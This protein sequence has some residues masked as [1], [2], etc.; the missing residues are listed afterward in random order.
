[1]FKSG[2]ARCVITPDI[3]NCPVPLAGLGR[4]DIRISNAVL[5]DITATA[6]VISDGED[7]AVLI[8][9]ETLYAGDL[10]SAKIRRA[11]SERLS[12][13]E[14]NITV[15]GT[16]THCS[17]AVE[18]VSNPNVRRWIDENAEKIGETAKKAYDALSET[19]LYGAS[20]QTDGINSV[21]RYKYADGEITSSVSTGRV[22]TSGEVAHE[23]EGDRE[24][25]VLRFK[26]RGGRDIIMVNFQTHPTGD[27]DMSQGIYRVSPQTFGRTREVFES[28]YPDVDYVYFNGAAGNVDVKGPMPEKKFEQGE[29]YDN[30]FIKYVN[31]ALLKAEPIKTGK[32]KA[33]TYMAPAEINHTRADL[34]DKAWEL[35][36]I[37]RN[38]KSEN[39]KDAY[40]AFDENGFRSIQ[41]VMS[42]I[43]NEDKLKG[44]RYADLYLSAISAGDVSFVSV[45]YEMFAESGAQV[46][47]ASPFKMTMIFS[48]A[49]G[50]WKYIPTKEAYDHGGFEPDVSF[51]LP[52]TGE[53]LVKDLTELNGKVR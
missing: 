6:V 42:C 16:H 36:L 24:M 21:R 25:L 31:E 37:W 30:E 4:M 47:K 13:P 19:E 46:K 9:V 23:S 35:R 39:H 45:P 18:E 14:K 8:S 29:P 20:V 10:F 41:Q 49:N 1:M 7:C 12:I 34:Y 22:N 3:K 50:A 53:K 2:F 52:G 15:S 38:D 28:R 51:F 48:N 40:R 5:R 27:G 32:I 11:V 43:R 26:R 44:Q 17:V 33:E